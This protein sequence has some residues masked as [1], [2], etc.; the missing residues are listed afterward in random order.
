M[1]LIKTLLFIAALIGIVVIQSAASMFIPF[2]DDSHIVM[3]QKH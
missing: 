3:K 1:K 2:Y